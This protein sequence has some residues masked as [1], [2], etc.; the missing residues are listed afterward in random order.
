MIESISHPKHYYV[1]YSTNIELRL[2][3]HNEGK[4]PALLF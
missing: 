3:A 4:T 2:K 1:G